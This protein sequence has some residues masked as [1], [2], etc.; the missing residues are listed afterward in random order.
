MHVLFKLQ[1]VWQKFLYI[2][3]YGLNILSTMTII[4]VV[5]YK[6][7]RGSTAFY[8]EIDC[9]EYSFIISKKLNQ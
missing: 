5:I 1:K 3:H 7:K 9:N 4:T 6:F 2:H 8:R